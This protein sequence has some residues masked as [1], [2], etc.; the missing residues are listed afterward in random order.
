MANQA[1]NLGMIFVVGLVLSVLVSLPASAGGKYPGW[2]LDGKYNQLYQVADMEDFKAVF[3]EQVELVPFKGMH[4]GTGL[5][6]YDKN[7]PDKQKI[8]LHLGPKGAFRLNKLKLRKGDVLKVRGVFAE[9]GDKEVFLCAKIKKK[10]LGEL[11]VRRTKDGK[12]IWT[13]SAAELAELAK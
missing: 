13:M 5:I 11:K 10:P 12:P 9:I 2:E 7:D 4:P 3:I 6:I 1:R 8:Q